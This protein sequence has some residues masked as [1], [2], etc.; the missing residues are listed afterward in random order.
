MLDSEEG[1]SCISGCLLLSDTKS[2]MEGGCRKYPNPA[3]LLSTLLLDLPHSKLRAHSPITVP[4]KHL[5]RQ[6]GG[7]RRM[8]SEPGGANRRCPTQKRK[9]F[10]LRNECKVKPSEED[11]CLASSVFPNIFINYFGDFNIHLQHFS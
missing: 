11:T 3:P 9:Q 1:K 4:Q 6:R 5:L 10:T 7:W 8:T 2:L